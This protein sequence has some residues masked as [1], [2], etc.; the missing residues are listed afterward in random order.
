MRK[1]ADQKK[2]ISVKRLFL[3]F[4]AITMVIIGFVVAKTAGPKTWHAILEMRSSYLL[5]AFAL[6]P[7]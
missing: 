3:I 7:G 2:G 5:L 6:A 1:T 4:C